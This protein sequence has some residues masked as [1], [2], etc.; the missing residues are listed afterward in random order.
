MMTEQEFDKLWQRAEAA[1]HAARLLEEYPA[2]RRNRRHDLGV[3]ALLL[4]AIVV[5]LPLLRRPHPSANHDTY[6][7]AYCNR[8][9]MTDQYWIEVAD[10][11]LMEV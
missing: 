4:V 8:P 3:A 5:A 2:W 1:P 6:T 7:A 11:L 10:A 9:D